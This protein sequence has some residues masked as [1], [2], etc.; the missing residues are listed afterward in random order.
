MR[1]DKALMRGKLE[2]GNMKYA[3]GKIAAFHFFGRHLVRA[4]YIE[5]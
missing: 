4:I 3:E 1:D 5:T 2:M